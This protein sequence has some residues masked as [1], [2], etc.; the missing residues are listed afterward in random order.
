MQIPAQI[1]WRLCKINLVRHEKSDTEYSH[2]SKGFFFLLEMVFYCGHF[3][4]HNFSPQKM[5]ELW[6]EI[7]INDDISLRLMCT[8][9]AGKKISL[10]SLCGRW[11]KVS[12][13]K[14]P[15]CL[16]AL[17]HQEDVLITRRSGMRQY[18]RLD[19][20]RNPGLLGHLQGLCVS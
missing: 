19:I 8:V 13:Y 4:P 15:T 11:K 7:L 18:F 10:I 20:L 2:Y 5:S 14:F 16:L 12:F 3:L 9:A 6:E 1:M 17:Q